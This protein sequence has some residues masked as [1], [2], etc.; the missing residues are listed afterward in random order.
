MAK[1]NENTFGTRINNAEALLLHLKS[2]DKYAPMNPQETVENLDKMIADLREINNQEAAKLQTY[3]LAVDI[4]Q[5]YLRGDEDSLKK[6]ITPVIA[7][8]RAAYG[9]ESREASSINAQISKIRGTKTTKPKANPDEKTNSTSQQ[10][11]NSLTQAFADLLAS[12]EVL[13]PVYNPPHEAVQLPK[14]KEKLSTIQQANNQIIT[15]TGELNKLR[16]QRDDSY[17]LLKVSCL[18]VKEAIKSLYGTG[19]T[20]YALVKGLKF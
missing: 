4:R 9:K 17:T 1:T 19:S 2:F 3:T 12:L 7:Y 13:S 18:R 14:L 5:K 16:K 15:V 8:V 20:E 11:Y 6:L 10:S